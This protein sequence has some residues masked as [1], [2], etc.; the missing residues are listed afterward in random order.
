MVKDQYLVD[1][2]KQNDL[3]ALDSIYL[4]YKEEFFLFART[5]SIASEDISDLYQETIIA[6]YEN[7]QSQK[8]E[9]L[10]S[11]LKTYLF[12]IGKFKIYKHLKKSKKI[13]HEENIIHVSEEMKVFETETADEQQL[14]LRKS[15]KELGDKC[16]QIL[17]LY[18]YKGMVLDDIQS[19]LK[20]S[21]KDVLKSQ[22]SRCLKQL[23]ALV[24]KRYE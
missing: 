14:V 2:L 16:Q 12:A 18:Y 9:R 20:Y 11:S 7:V 6:L 21:S 23:K 10:S 3:K 8:L 24:R 5:F 22:K 17:D 19:T 1:K 13:Y 4:T 15:W